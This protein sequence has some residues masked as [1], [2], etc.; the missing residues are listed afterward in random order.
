MVITIPD[1]GH[2]IAEAV[3]KEK[4]RHGAGPNLLETD[5]LLSAVKA[6]KKHTPSGGIVLLSPAAPSYGIFGSFE[7]R[8]EIFRKSTGLK[9]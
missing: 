7:E 6:A 9:N 3:R 8:G 2:R 1:N 4:E 5:D